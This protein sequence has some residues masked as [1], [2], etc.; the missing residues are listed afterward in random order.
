MTEA[1]A[2]EY[3]RSGVRVNVVVPGWI[4]TPMVQR[5]M[6]NTPGLETGIL[7]HEPTGRMGTP[8]EVAEAVVWLCSDAASYVT[9]HT[10]IIDGGA[11]AW[12]GGV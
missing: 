6:Q 1:G 11:T 9:G 4:D 7:E 10:M 8:E 2:L 5:G 3:A 12:G